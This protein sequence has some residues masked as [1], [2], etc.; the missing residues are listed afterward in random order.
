MPA[1]QLRTA[2][3]AVDHIL[4]T[5]GKRVVLGVPLGLGKGFGFYSP[6]IGC[7]LCVGAGWL[8]GLKILR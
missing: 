5:V 2:E 1:R 4:A 3:E 8:L 7:A 6:F